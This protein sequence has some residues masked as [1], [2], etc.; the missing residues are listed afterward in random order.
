MSDFRASSILLHDGIKERS[1]STLARVPFLRLPE[2]HM[3]HMCLC[4]FAILCLH[5]ILYSHSV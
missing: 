3:S 1:Q 5:N 2:S 4:V